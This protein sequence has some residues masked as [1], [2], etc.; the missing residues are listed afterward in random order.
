MDRNYGMHTATK[1]VLLMSFICSLTIVELV[2]I[3][4]ILPKRESR[5]LLRSS[6]LPRAP[7]SVLIIPVSFYLR[8]RILLRP[9]SRMAGK[10]RKRKVCPVGA[11]SNTIVSKSIFSIVLTH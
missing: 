10:F 8:V 11:V 4:S 6:L 9:F 7:P 1:V 3:F 5:A 2:F